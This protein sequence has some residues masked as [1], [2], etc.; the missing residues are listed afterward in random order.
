[1]VRD[2]MMEPVRKVQ[3]AT[4]FKRVCDFLFPPISLVLTFSSDRR[5]LHCDDHLTAEKEDNEN[6]AVLCMALVDNG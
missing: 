3:S 4:H 6:C 1:V 5:H 2:A